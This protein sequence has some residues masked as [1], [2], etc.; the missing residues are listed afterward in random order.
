LRPFSVP[1]QF[2]GVGKSTSGCV[3]NLL[4]K[5]DMPP[6]LVFAPFAL[7]RFMVYIL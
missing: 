4:L 3:N 5:D 7:A 1:Y 2:D 6:R